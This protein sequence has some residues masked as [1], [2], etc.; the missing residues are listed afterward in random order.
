MTDKLKERFD[1]VFPVNRACIMVF[2]FPYVDPEKASEYDESHRE[3]ISKYI[4]GYDNYVKYYVDKFIKECFGDDAEHMA[5]HV[6]YDRVI[7]KDDKGY[8]RI[9]QYPYV[10]LD[11]LT[12]LFNIPTID[13]LRYNGTSISP[14]HYSNIRFGFN[15][16][17]SN[18]GDIGT[19]KSVLSY[20]VKISGIQD[21]RILVDDDRIELG[22]RRSE[23]GKWVKEYHKLVDEKFELI[24]NRMYPKGS[25]ISKLDVS[26]NIVRLYIMG[27]YGF[28]TSEDGNIVYYVTLYPL[29]DEHKTIPHDEAFNDCHGMEV[30]TLD[31]F[32]ELAPEYSDSEFIYELLRLPY[33]SDYKV[34]TKS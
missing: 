22:C 4:S 27:D 2:G 17:T 11:Y 29:G 1:E 6:L 28:T 18:P 24:M 20:H 3:Y 31:E 19:G 10:E 5:M 23:L 12:I 9:I 33:G 30:I 21:M 8:Q 26:D 15:D 25:L 34:A 16:L 32:N 14:L 7:G 13:E